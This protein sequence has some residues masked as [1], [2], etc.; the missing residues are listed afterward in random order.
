MMIGKMKKANI[1]FTS[2]KDLNSIDYDKTRV[3]TFISI[4]EDKSFGVRPDKWNKRKP[5]EQVILQKFEEKLSRNVNYTSGIVSLDKAFTTINNNFLDKKD[6]KNQTKNLKRSDTQS[7][8]LDIMKDKG[9]VEKTDKLIQKVF[10]KK[11][12][13]KDKKP[14]PFSGPKSSCRSKKN[15]GIY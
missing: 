9:E 5:K 15:N 10:V 13:I 1:S 11:S 7:T 8:I 12:E 4:E 2:Y 3:N 14:I 6:E